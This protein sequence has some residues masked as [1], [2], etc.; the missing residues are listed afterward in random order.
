VLQ[1]PCKQVLESPELLQAGQQVQQVPLERVAQVPQARRK[2]VQVAL[3]Q[4]VPRRLELLRVQVAPE[5][6]TLA[7]LALQQVA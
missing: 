6:G 1:V 4:Q 2:L 5:A 7:L 3:V